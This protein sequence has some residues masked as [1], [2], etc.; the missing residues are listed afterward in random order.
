MKLV[1][2]RGEQVVEFSRLGRLLFWRDE[3]GAEHEQ[4]FFDDAAAEAALQVQLDTHRQA[5]WSEPPAV[6]EAQARAAEAARARQ[7]QL[8]AQ[9]TW[10][11]ELTEQADAPAAFRSLTGALLGSIDADTLTQLSELVAKLDDATAHG[12]TVFFRNGAEADWGEEVTMFARPSERD[13]ERP[14]LEFAVTSGPP[15]G[16][17]EIED[18]VSGDI[19]WFMNESIFRFWFF[20]SDE[21]TRARMWDHDGGIAPDPIKRSPAQAFADLL[22]KFASRA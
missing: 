11:R 19:T 12:V 7:Q 16:D 18:E 6:L 8:A 22:L 21:P 3:A 2:Q 17:E 15:L 4:G 5:G 14:C 9:L 10:H 1:L 13:A 20:T